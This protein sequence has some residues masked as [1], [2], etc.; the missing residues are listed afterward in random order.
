MATPLAR[1]RILGVRR[2]ASNGNAPDREQMPVNTGVCSRF[3]WECSQF[4]VVVNNGEGKGFAQL[5]RSDRTQAVEYLRN[6]LELTEKTA[7]VLGCL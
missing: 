5:W 6:D 7:K 4:A 1:S 3:H 2:I